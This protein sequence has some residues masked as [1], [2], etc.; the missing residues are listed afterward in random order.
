M[1]YRLTLNTLIV[2]G[3]IGVLLVNGF[4][5][6]Q[7]YRQEGNATYIKP[8]KGD[9]I[10]HCI[11]ELHMHVDRENVFTYRVYETG[12]GDPAMNGNIIYVSL[13]DGWNYDARE[14][15][16]NI[17]V[18]KVKNIKWDTNKI[19]IYATEHIMLKTGEITTQDATYTIT[20]F[21]NQENSEET[22]LV[23]TKK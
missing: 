2:L 20:W 7:E 19:T 1:K 18:Y 15:R 9:E 14:W 6:A 13:E 8:I 17:N 23:I 16:T 3:L 5:Y 4:L 21:W 22:E 10:L 12:G 11:F